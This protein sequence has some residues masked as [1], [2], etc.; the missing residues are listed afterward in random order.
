[1][2]DLLERL[3]SEKTT[4]NRLLDSDESEVLLTFGEGHYQPAL[5]LLLH[6]ALDSNDHYCCMHAVQGLLS[7]DL[8]AYRDRIESALDSIHRDNSFNEWL[9]GMLPHTMPTE[10]KLQEYYEIGTWISNDRSAGILFGM[11]L[12]DGG[13]TYFQRALNDPEWEIDDKGVSLWRVADLIKEKL[14][15]TPNSKPRSPNTEP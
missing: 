11:S 3:F 2:S 7:W 6:Y 8:S 14:A 10:E 1:M 5:P 15:Q 12:S 4:A 13:K 9:P